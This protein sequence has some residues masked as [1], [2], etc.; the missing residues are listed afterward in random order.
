M[1]KKKNVYS[2]P[3][4]PF[5]NEARR[6]LSTAQ[7]RALVAQSELLMELMERVGKLE[8]ILKKLFS[9]QKYLFSFR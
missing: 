6:L 7:P 1:D 3:T 2:F 8:G 5:L 4:N 9:T